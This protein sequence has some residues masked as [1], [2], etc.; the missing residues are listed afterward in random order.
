M[1]HDRGGHRGLCLVVELLQREHERAER[2]GPQQPHR[3]RHDPGECLIARLGAPPGRAQGVTVERPVPADVLL[4]LPLQ[5]EPGRRHLRGVVHGRRL[6]GQQLRCRIPQVQQRPQLVGRR[7]RHRVRLEPSRRDRGEPRVGCDQAALP[8]FRW[9]GDERRAPSGL[10]GG[11]LRH[12]EALAAAVEHELVDGGGE[13]FLE[14]CE[15]GGHGE[16]VGLVHAVADPD[17]SDDVLGVLVEPGVDPQ[18]HAVDGHLSHGLP[19][20]VADRFAVSAAAEHQ[21]VGQHLGA[22]R[23]PVRSRR[24]ADRADEVGQLVH[25]ATSA[26]V[27]RVHR[28]VRSQHGDEP[29][30]PGQPQ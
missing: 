30:G 18:R 24:Q 28:E 22:C 26:G 17:L 2:V 25:L 10:L 6:H 12:R 5:R 14:P 20:V 8:Q 23:A 1:R 27:L 3:G 13:L 11:A 4:V 15:V 9:R 16:G 19:Q 21:Q 29:A 7:L